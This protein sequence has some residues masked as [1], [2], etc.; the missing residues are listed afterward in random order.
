[1]P[2]R[3]KHD[4]IPFDNLATV[5]HLRSRLHNEARHEPNT[6]NEERTVLACWACNNCRGVCDQKSVNPV[7]LR[8]RITGNMF[9]PVVGSPCK[10]T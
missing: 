8:V 2:E 4:A 3:G 5:D 6:L 1:M 9:Y 10:S 7:V